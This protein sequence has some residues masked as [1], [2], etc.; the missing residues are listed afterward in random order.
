MGGP[1]LLTKTRDRLGESNGHE[2]GVVTALI[3]ITTRTSCRHAEPNHRQEKHR[4]EGSQNEDED[5]QQEIRLHL[6]GCG[7]A[8]TQALQRL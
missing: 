4:T 1:F 5:E 2:R 8:S 7:L 6:K 3:E